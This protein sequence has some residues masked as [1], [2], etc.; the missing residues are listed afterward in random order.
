MIVS[1]N[2]IALSSNT[3]SSNVPIALA[4]QQLGYY[5]NI[6][7]F[8]NYSNE[9]MIINDVGYVGI[10]TLFP[11]SNLHV[12]GSFLL[13]GPGNFTQGVYVGQNIEIWGN[14]IAHGNNITDSD[15]RIKKDLEKIDSALEKVKKL[16][17]YTFTNVQS[18]YRNTGLVAQD[19]QKILPEAVY[20]E[21]KYLGLAYGNLMGLIVEAIKDLSGEIDEIKKRLP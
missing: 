4:V 1:S 19:V 12:H 15:I 13:E 20:T 3:P 21:G 18:G 5:G 14:A 6:A 16:T 17:G 7:H 2:T 11:Q 10:N 9:G 8:Y